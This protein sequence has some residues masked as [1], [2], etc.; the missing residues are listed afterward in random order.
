M[1]PTMCII[2][3]KAR[4]RSSGLLSELEPWWQNLLTYPPT[5]HYVHRWFAFV[6]LG[7]AIW[8]FYLIK[9]RGLASNLAKGVKTMIWLTAVQITLG[10]SVIW[11]DVPVWLA[12]V[13]QGM[14]ISLLL[15]TIFINHRLWFE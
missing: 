9:N 3:L 10:V 6:V 1:S 12:I 11:F 2:Q 5:V 4:A 15:A 14:A 7:V 13:H 8:L